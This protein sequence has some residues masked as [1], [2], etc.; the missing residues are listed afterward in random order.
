MTVCIAST[1]LLTLTLSVSDL[2]LPDPLV[3]SGG[4]AVTTPEQWRDVRRPEILELFRTHMYGRRP[5][6]RPDD[7]RFELR[8]VTPDAMDGTATRKLVDILYSGPGG[9]GKIQLILFIPNDAPK[10]AP[11][12]VLICHRD[13]ENIDP[14]RETKMPFWPAE[15]IV[16]RGY[17]AATFHV[18]DVAPDDKETWKQGVYTLFPA[19]DEAEAWG[20]ISIWGW[21]ASRILDYFETD[22]DIDETHVAVVGHSRGGKAAL[23][24]GAEDE[25]FALTCSNDSGCTGAALARRKQGESVHL[26]NSRFPHWFCPNYDAFNGREEALPVDQHELV[27]LM[28]PRLVYVASASEDDW[29]D[30]EGEFLSCVH[31]SPVYTLF[32]LDGVSATEMPAPDQ[33][34][35]GGHIGYHLRSGKHD[36]TEYDWHRYMDFADKHWGKAAR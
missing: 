28:A 14:T 6:G 22:A 9:E 36:L 5:V 3:T 12:F 27:A 15:Q 35:Q 31:A 19:P 21:G 30:P 10:P 23:C 11:A 13:P 16:A 24:C 2:N 25:R 4:D 33:P 7:L 29:A 32:R 34:L 1:L 26:I 18:S 20:A 17:A 8:E